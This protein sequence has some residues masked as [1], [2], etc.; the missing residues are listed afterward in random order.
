MKAFQHDGRMNQIANTT[1]KTST[2]AAMLRGSTTINPPVRP[3]HVVLSTGPH[4][5]LAP[6]STDRACRLN[7][8]DGWCGGP[9]RRPLF[10]AVV[11]SLCLVSFRCY[12]TPYIDATRGTYSYV[13]ASHPILASKCRPGLKRRRH[14]GVTSG[15]CKLSNESKPLLGLALGTGDSTEHP[16]LVTHSRLLQINSLD[17]EPI[18]DVRDGTSPYLCR[19]SRKF[20]FFPFFSSALLLL[21]GLMISY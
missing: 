17:T 18:G 13:D 7:C 9:I 16:F 14:L 4:L 2:L 20:F 8:G 6:M 10:S 21:L 12:S 19:L 3:G 5:I 11:S 15:A 1:H